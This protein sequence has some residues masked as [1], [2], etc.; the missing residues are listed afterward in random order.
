MMMRQ[1]WNEVGCGDGGKRDVGDGVE[2]LDT[3]T[4][5]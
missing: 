1:P 5:S 2:S 3:V 4:E